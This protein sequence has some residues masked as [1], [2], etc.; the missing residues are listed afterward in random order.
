M[1]GAA[2]TVA[3]NSNLAVGY[4][5]WLQDTSLLDRAKMLR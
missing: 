4:R 2:G 1:V 5:V 3:S